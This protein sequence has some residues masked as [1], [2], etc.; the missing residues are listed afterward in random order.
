MSEVVGAQAG[1][2]GK[3]WGMCEGRVC[4]V[5][6]S[7]I[8]WGGGCVSDAWKMTHSGTRRRSTDLNMTGF[9]GWRGRFE[10]DGLRVSGW[11]GGWI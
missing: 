11:V 8:A 9:E 6:V 1:F 3:V 5:C 10:Y 7:V 4:G 2:M